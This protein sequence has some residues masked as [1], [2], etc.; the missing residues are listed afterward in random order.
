MAADAAAPGPE[1]F[2]DFVCIDWSGAAVARPP[3]LAVAHARAGSAAPALVNPALLHPAGGWTRPAILDWLLAHADAGT[4][5]LVGLDLSPGFPFADHGAY[6]PGWADSPGD[7]RA[8]WALVDRLAG[9]EP[10]LAANRFIDHP[11]ASRY[12][13]RHGQPLG[14]RFGAAGRGRLREVEARQRSLALA[15]AS[16]FNLVGA[17]QVGKSSL[18]G[19]RLLHRLGGRIPVWPFDPLP[20]SGPVI[21]EIYTSLAARAAGLPAGRSKLRDGIALDTALARLGSAAHTPLP[22]YTDHAT[23][24]MLTAAWLRRAAGDAA[25]WHPPGLDAVRHTE[26]WTFGVG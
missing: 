26:G 13:R 3:G 15:P 23:D 10:H 4:P 19:M 25:L 11:E 2:R 16:C 20:D 14:D 22:R 17:A 18:T 5:M 6:F 21:V 9:D 1:R 12:F 24:A 8:L 7:A